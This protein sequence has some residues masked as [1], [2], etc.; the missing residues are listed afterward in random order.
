MPPLESIFVYLLSRVAASPTKRL[1]S[2]STKKS[3]PSPVQ[4][5]PMHQLIQLFISVLC[6]TILRENS[7]W[8]PHVRGVTR[9]PNPG[10]PTPAVSGTWLKVVMISLPTS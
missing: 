4:L 3:N 1:F 8:E 10:L 7:E 9:N 5:S 6:P 2:L